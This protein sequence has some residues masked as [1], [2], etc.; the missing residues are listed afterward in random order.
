MGVKSSVVLSTTYL[1]EKVRIGKGSKGGLFVFTRAD[2]SNESLKEAGQESLPVF[3]FRG[4]DIFEGRHRI[5]GLSDL[6]LL[7]ECD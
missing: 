4:F 1:D 7:C 5:F 6:Q 3:V 2:G